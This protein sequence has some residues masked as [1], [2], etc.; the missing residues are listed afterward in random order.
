VVSDVDGVLTDGCVGISASGHKFRTFHVHDGMGVKLLTAAGIRVGWLSSS[1]DDGVIRARAAS[2]G[3]N[4]VDVSDGDKGQRL[5]RLADALGAPLASI[6]YIGDDVNDL[7]A[8]HLAAA[9]ACPSDARPEVR[10]VVT[11]VLNAPGGRGAFREAADLVLDHLGAPLT[12]P[13]SIE[14]G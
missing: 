5:R 10:S 6:V 14:P 2:L 11:R 3:V 8:I 7:P 13:P 12:V 4:A 1:Q 9:S